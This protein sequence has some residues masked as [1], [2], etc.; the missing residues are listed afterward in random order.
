MFNRIC[1][2]WALA[3]SVAFAVA[4]VASAITVYIDPPAQAVIHNFLFTA[5]LVVTGVPGANGI[6]NVDLLL[7][8]DPTLISATG[9]SE[10][11][12]FESQQTGEP[13]FG[14]S[15]IDN[16]AG[17]VS[18]SFT[19]LGPLVSTGSGT[20]ATITFVSGFTL[21]G[22]SN[23]TYTLLMTQLDATPVP[24]TA[25]PGSVEVFGPPIDT[26]TP[27]ETSP[28]A[29][30]TPTLTP[31]R[32]PTPTGT[33]I[34][35][36]TPFPNTRCRIALG[37]MW[38]GQIQNPGQE[39][40][41]LFQGVEG[42]VVNIT[43]RPSILGLFLYG[44]LP[45]RPRVQLLDPDSQILVDFGESM[46]S[47]GSTFRLQNYTLQKNGMYA[48]KIRG[49]AFAT[50]SYMVST[51]ARYPIFS[52][53]IT[54]TLEEDEVHG[55]NYSFGGMDGMAIT[56]TVQ[57]LTFAPGYPYVNLIDP[58][59]HLEKADREVRMTL[60]FPGTFRV[61]VLGEDGWLGV[62]LLRWTGTYPR[63][64]RFLFE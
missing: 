61:Q 36:P 18:F 64:G 5:H 2:R 31:T 28:P 38:F 14:F 58:L 62:Y 44:T 29:T 50:G 21:N 22:T 42:A 26:P 11:P 30:P 23:L 4:N 47:G 63:G 19:R 1:F 39:D 12:F 13:F 52:Q 45:V 34:I 51:R 32:T 9:V 49:S 6:N 35:T 48:L 8:F 27:T 46:A 40:V 7:S 20:L 24:F 17:T 53:T 56:I 41:C 3:L 43:V 54:G 33:H 37:D 16:T 15:S 25:T 55:D 60:D 10:G 57:P 59:G